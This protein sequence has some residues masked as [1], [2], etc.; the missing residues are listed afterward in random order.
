MFIYKL[1]HEISQML[2]GLQIPYMLTGSLAYN[3]YAIPRA[4]RDID[5]IIEIQQ[6]DVMRFLQAIQ[7]KYYF[8][9]PTIIEEIKRHG[10]FNII[11]LESSYK[12]DFIV[13]SDDIFEIAKFKERNAIEF[14]GNKLYVISLENLII[15]KLR[16]IQLL[17]SELHKRD[18]ETLLKSPNVNIEYIKQWCKKLNLNTYNLIDYE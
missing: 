14:E 3:L 1:L 13:R 18:I 12:I 5:M 16:W 9:E 11:H 10:L 4:T 15:S 2:N 6:T 17:E 7:G 8:Y